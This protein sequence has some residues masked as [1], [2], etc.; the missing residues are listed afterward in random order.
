MCDPSGDHAAHS[1]DHPKQLRLAVAETCYT[2]HK[3]IKDH[4]AAANE[5]W[6]DHADK[7]QA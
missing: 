4:V 1:T 7:R 5:L 2:C 3:T 6:R